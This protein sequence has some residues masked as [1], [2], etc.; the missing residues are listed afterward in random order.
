MILVHDGD[1]IMSGDVIWQCFVI[2]CK[3]TK[4]R[5]VLCL[6]TMKER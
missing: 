2:R 3:L 5:D 6:G 4:K 1:V